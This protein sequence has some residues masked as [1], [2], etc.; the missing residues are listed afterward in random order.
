MFVG[1]PKSPN[2]EV[3]PFEPSIRKRHN[4]QDNPNYVFDNFN[5]ALNGTITM[6]NGENMHVCTHSN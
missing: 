3:K 5:A 6:P 2:S 4:R 1:V